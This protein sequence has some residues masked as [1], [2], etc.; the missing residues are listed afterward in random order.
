MPTTSVKD[1]EKLRELI[2]RQQFDIPVQ[3]SVQ[4]YFS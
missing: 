2:P 1:G 3:L 4:N